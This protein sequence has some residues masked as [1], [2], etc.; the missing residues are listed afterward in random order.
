[1][2]KGFL[3]HSALRQ[4]LLFALVGALAALCHF[5]LLNFGVT[6]LNLAPWLA[7]IVGFGG[8]F[9]VSFYGHYRLTF[10]SEK[11]VQAA[12]PLY[13]LLRWAAVAVG[14]FLGNQALYVALLGLWGNGYFRIAWLVA[15]LIVAALSFLLG[16]LWAF[17]HG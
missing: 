12:L 17:R 2:R 7:N 11:H 13:A 1:M 10:A 6:R 9:L 4:P 14:G 16:K 8:A 15:T 3:S 5:T